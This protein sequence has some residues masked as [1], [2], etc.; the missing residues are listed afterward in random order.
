MLL[1][2][3]KRL[4]KIVEL[5]IKWNKN[6]WGVFKR[7]ILFKVSDVRRLFEKIFVIIY[8]FVWKFMKYGF[9]LW[10][11]VMDECNILWSNNFSEFN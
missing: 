5:F 4:I 3:D 1:L 7:K 6:V 9:F 10:M 2:G 11:I 8:F